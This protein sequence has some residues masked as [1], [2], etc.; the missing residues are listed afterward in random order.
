MK[1]NCRIFCNIAILIWL[2]SILILNTTAEVTQ[3]ADSFSVND[4]SGP[5]GNIIQ[6]PDIDSIISLSTISDGFDYPIGSLYVTQAN[7]GDG[8]YNA[9]EFGVPNPNYGN[10]L[11]L[12]EDW[13]GEDGGNTDCGQPVYSSSKGTIVYANFASGW[14]NVIIVRH[15]LPS[16]NQV[17]TLYGH[18]QVMS[19]TSGDVNRREQIG[20]IGDGSGTNPPCHLHFEIRDQSSPSWGSPGP[21]DQTTVSVSLNFI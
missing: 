10:Q 5:T 20:T 2:F 19:R 1:L 16:G 13:N 15:Q 12:G 11:H 4:A 8:W 6:V 3:M 17:E 21:G 18:L 14:G 9:Q 7:D